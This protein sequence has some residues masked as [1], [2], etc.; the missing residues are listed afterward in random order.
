MTLERWI[1]NLQAKGRYT[2][3]RAEAITGSGLSPDAVKKALQ[4]MAR[5]G[6]VVKVKDYFYVIAEIT[7]EKERRIIEKFEI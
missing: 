2:F 1:N 4:R 5:R 6:R 3:L 7:G